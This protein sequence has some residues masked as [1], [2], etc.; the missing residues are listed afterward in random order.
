MVYV[1]VG[2]GMLPVQDSSGIY[3]ENIEDSLGVHKRFIGN[4]KKYIT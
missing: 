1:P 2:A 3:R 4:I